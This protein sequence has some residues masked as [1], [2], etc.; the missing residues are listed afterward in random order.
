MA[1]SDTQSH[2]DRHAQALAKIMAK[3]E[4]PETDQSGGKKQVEATN[5]M[6]E[7]EKQMINGAE[8]LTIFL[9]LTSS[10]G[11]PRVE[12]S[13]PTEITAERLR[14]LVSDAS[15]VPNA[16]MKLIFRGRMITEQ[17]NEML[18]VDEFA[19]QNES[20][21]HVVGKPR[22]STKDA[23]DMALLQKEKIAVN[24]RKMRAASRKKKCCLPLITNTERNLLKQSGIRQALQYIIEQQQQETWM[25]CKEL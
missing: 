5:R 8:C 18:V 3:K 9:L 16:E 10:P 20:A 24:P 15:G 19:I 4:E 1:E 6:L 13:I 17:M 11:S 7:E 2:R 21:L 22:Q 14:H 12:L 23:D 25:F